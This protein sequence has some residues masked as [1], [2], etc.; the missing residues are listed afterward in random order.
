M[1]RLLFVHDDAMAT[2]R[3]LRHLAQREPS[4]D[5]QIAA[6]EDDAWDLFEGWVP[7]VVIAAARKSRL[8]G[9]RL[10]V[11]VR[12]ARPET[13]RIVV[14]VDD[15]AEHG[16][17]ALRIAHRAV[18]EPLDPATLVEVVRRMILMSQL[19]AQPGMRELLGRIDGLPA[20]P[21]VH[22]KLTHRLEDPTVSVFELSEMVAAD[23]TLSAQV[24]RIANS[25]FF[26]RHQRVTKIEAAAARLG[27][28]L[29]G[30]LVLTAE[31][32][33]RFPV[34]PFMAERLEALQTHASMVARLASNLEPSAPW[35]DDAFTA[36]LLHDIGKLV[37]A[38]HLPDVHQSIVRDAERT[39][40]PEHEVELQRLGVHHGAIGACLLGMWGLPS[41]IL[42][43]ALQHDQVLRE[44]PATLDAVSAVTF[45]NHLAHL[46]E[47]PE[48]RYARGRSLPPA[49]L[50]DPRWTLWREMAFE[51]G[52]R[53][54]AA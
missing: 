40:R 34:S 22:T 27:T 41:V 33:G 11:R 1:P 7:D 45:A 53:E 14:G 6:S 54:E 30:S 13:V 23:S 10:L 25:A 52:P 26:S 9:L 8:D 37:L 36:G 31:A 24:L 12:D 28:R 19:V 20:A 5:I 39:N 47:Q 2:E 35:R 42:E 18:V 49:V 44:I 29:L 17:R 3:L 48:G 51:A 50:N 21:S 4:W 16:L 38:S 46:S 15:D 43:A 32:F